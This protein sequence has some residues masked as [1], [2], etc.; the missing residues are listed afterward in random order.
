MRLLNC[1]HLPQ[2]VHSGGTHL[3]LN[4]YLRENDHE[5]HREAHG[6]DGC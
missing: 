1:Q 4:R 6:R 3:Q 2:R 5:L